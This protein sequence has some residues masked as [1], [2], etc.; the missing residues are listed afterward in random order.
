MNYAQNLV[1]E[2]EAYHTMVVSRQAKKIEALTEEERVETMS[3]VTL[4]DG[5]YVTNGLGLF[6]AELRRVNKN[7]QFAANSTETGMGWA[8]SMLPW[9]ADSL[10]VYYKGDRYVMA[11]VAYGDTVGVRRSEVKKFAVFSRKIANA[12]YGS[13]RDQFY[14]AASVDLGKAVK[15]FKRY[16]IP[17]APYEIAQVSLRA[18]VQCVNHVKTKPSHTLREATRNVKS[19]ESFW[20]DVL[21]LYE[22]GHKF[23]SPTVNAEFQ[24]MVDAKRE[25]RE[26][27]MKATHLCAVE[28]CY[29][30]RF[31]LTKVLGVSSN[32]AYKQLPA[33]PPVNVTQEELP[34]GIQ[35]KLA[36][37]S[38]MGTD[39]YVE[40]IGVRAHD[41]LYWVHIDGNEV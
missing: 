39:E 12:K 8:G 33:T 16:A 22:S 29:D 5:V 14:M 40:D 6:I 26:R 37:L 21:R 2:A 32:T 38:M 3:Q 34:E 25:E 15:N 28:L 24:A 4:V 36:L 9:T 35:Q 1:T 41:W 23:S 19:N 13:Y 10:S 7:L 11:M 18:A 20:D 30:G 31:S 17:Y 27:G